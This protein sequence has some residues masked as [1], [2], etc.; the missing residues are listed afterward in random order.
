MKKNYKTKKFCRLSMKCSVLLCSILILGIASAF[1]SSTVYGQ[2]TVQRFSLKLENASVLDALREVNRLSGNSVVFKKEEVEKETKRVT[3]DLKDVTTLE[4]VRACLAGTKLSCAESDGK[5]VVIPEKEQKAKIV[6]GIISDASGAPLPGA[7]VVVKG[8]ASKIGTSANVNGEYQIVV[9]AGTSVLI[10]SFIGYKS[11]EVEIKE[12]TKINVSL[13]ED[14]KNVDEVVVVAYG[15]QN[16]RDVLGAMSTVNADDIKDIPSPSLANLLQ[17]RVAG[18][19]VINM[20]GAPGGGGTS[21][22]IR[23]FNS[24]SVEAAQRFSNPLWV[25]DGVPMHSFTSPISG[26]N[27]LAEIDPKDIESVQVLKDAASASIYGSRAANGVILVTTKKGRF[28][29]KARVSINVSQTMIFNPS[30]PDLTGGNR[31]RYHRMEALRN[32]QEAGFSEEQNRYLY[33]G[34]YKESY[35]R[36]IA[37]DYFWGKGNGAGVPLYQDSLNKFYN[38]STN[39]FDYY[40]RTAQVTDA[41]LQLTGGAE[42]V[43]YNVGLGYYKE[44]GVLRGT[45][46]NRMKLLSNM[47]I[48]PIDKMD[49]NMRFYLAYTDRSRSSEEM[50]TL[51]FDTGTDLEQIPKELL[52]TSTLYPGK[53]S[54]A[55][56][57]A[58]RRFR[59]TKEEND[60]YRIRTSFDLSYEFIKGLSFKTSVALDFSQQNV[61]IFLPSNLNDYNESYSN[62]QVGRNMMLLNENLLTYKRTFAENHNVDFLLGLSLQSDEAN[63]IGGY[64]YKAP[65]DLIHY[66]P[67]YKNAYDVASDR[68]LKEYLSTKKK[69]TMVGVFGR[70]NYNYMQKY[71]LSFSL[72]RDGSSKFGEDVRWATFP[73]YAV[74]Y[75]FSEEPFMDW[76]KDVLDYAKIRVSYGKSGK[77]FSEPY[78][79]LGLLEPSAP[80]LGNPTV[81]P[82]W[83]EGLFNPTLTWEETDQYD[84]GLD[85]D[86][87]NYRVNVVLDYYYRYTD[88]LLYNVTLAGNHSAYIKQWQNAYAISNEGIEL[89]IKWDILRRDDLKWDMTFNI[90]RNWNRLEKSRNGADFQTYGNAGYFDS[91]ISIIGKPLNGLYVYKDKGYYNS[92]DE[93][94]YIYED[95]RKIYLHGNGYRQYFRAGDRIMVDVD[96]NGSVYTSWPLQEDRVYAGSPL[97]KASGGIVSTLSWKGL[98]V[99]VLFSYVIS[100]HILNSR[101]GASLGTSLGLEMDDLTLPIFADLDDV[102]FWKKPGDKADFPMNRLESGL[103]N[104]TT[105]LMSNV[106]NVSYLKLKTLTVGYT[107]P[108]KWTKRVGM[109]N[110]RVFVSGENLFTI[111]NYTGPDPESV[112]LVTGVD[113]FANYPLSTRVTL[114]L[115]LNF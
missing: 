80:F 85:V 56:D 82:D 107:L 29:Q 92:D 63:K 86:L 38:N 76:A 101:K 55:F 9:P 103:G 43:T 17:G 72:R 108:N 44:T 49:A 109:D 48:K 34:S 97:P 64:G 21:I 36:D 83:D 15:T 51:S 66:V 98:D 46:F 79:A 13:E 99:N 62:G 75:A 6:S 106:E 77:Q 78:I 32:N 18:M 42:R 59:G 91:N 12:Q 2:K 90:A 65:S 94:P 1:T 74:G 37:Y 25:I 30:L 100:R 45:G 110:V 31:E 104:F 19:S 7:T 40:F 95:G 11:K 69:S 52:E 28:N 89:Q 57:E 5:V 60:S 81:A 39:L 14:V 67:W 41:S 47:T 20:T 58:T 24:L 54:A 27:T 33:V 102:T 113:N 22:S 114:G 4:A 93:V 10:Y 8:T 16:K 84:V 111:T 61:N 87:F 68:Q 70:L 96:G 50:N 71:L 26:L 23:G 112:D 105:T 115:T 35:L 88:K 53:G 73:A 3:V